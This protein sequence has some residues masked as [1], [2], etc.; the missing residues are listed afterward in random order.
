MGVPTI[1]LIDPRRRTGVIVDRAGSHP[2][3]LMT[4]TDTPIQV[5]LAEIFAELDR[6][7]QGN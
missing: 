4:V 7:Q 5:P 6:A 2:A 3:H 1:W